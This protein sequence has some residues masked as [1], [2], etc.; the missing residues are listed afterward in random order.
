[1]LNLLGD[2]MI[3]DIF[4]ITAIIASVLYVISGFFFMV[5]YCVFDEKMWIQEVNAYL[6][7]TVVYC[8]FILWINGDVS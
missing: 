2:F 6:L 7:V 3:A 4:L 5:A 1:M 8:F